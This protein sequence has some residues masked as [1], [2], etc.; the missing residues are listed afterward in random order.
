MAFYDRREPG[1]SLEDS[2]KYRTLKLGLHQ[3]RENYAESHGIE[4]WEKGIEAEKV[5]IETEANR[6]ASFDSSE[7]ASRAL[8]NSGSRLPIF[9]SSALYRVSPNLFPESSQKIQDDLEARSLSEKSLHLETQSVSEE[10]KLLNEY[11][12]LSMPT[13][14]S[15]SKMTEMRDQA[16]ILFD[17]DEVKKNYGSQLEEID[18]YEAV[19]EASVDLRSSNLALH[20]SRELDLL[21]ESSIKTG[22]LPMMQFAPDGSSLTGK[23]REDGSGNP[24]I[25]SFDKTSWAVFQSGDENYLVPHVSNI[26][27]IQDEEIVLGFKNGETRVSLASENLEGTNIHEDNVSRSS[28]SYYENELPH[29]KIFVDSTLAKEI[30][31]REA[32][33][34]QEHGTKA[35]EKVALDNLRSR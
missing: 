6:L 9:L 7:I 4:L 35:R 26:R 34:D 1:L 23:F 2:E 5:R 17:K 29:T 16:K 14:A 22:S 25:V 12:T 21:N 3:A 18:R 15:K 19:I 20:R 33:E 24:Q 8:E 28:M 13:S 11:L 31:R 32:R 10:E 27:H 30:E